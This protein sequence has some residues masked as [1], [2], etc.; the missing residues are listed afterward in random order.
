[1]AAACAAALPLAHTQCARAATRAGPWA[2]GNGRE[3]TPRQGPCLSRAVFPIHDARGP[4]RARLS[5]A[6]HAL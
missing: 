4:P 2:M 5:I 3:H 1:M 6:V